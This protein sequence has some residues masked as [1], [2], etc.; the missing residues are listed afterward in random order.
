MAA[1]DKV[2]RHKLSL[3]EFAKDLSNIRGVGKVTSCSRQPFTEIRRNLW[4]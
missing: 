1:K 4:G 2:A 3:L